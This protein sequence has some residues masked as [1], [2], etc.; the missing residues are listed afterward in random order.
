MT[1]RAEGAVGTVA[2]AGGAVWRPGRD[3]GLETAVVHRPRYDDWS[4]PKGKLDPGEHPLTAAVREVL[5]ETGL[6]AVAGRRSVT[7]RYRVPDGD[8]RVDYWL[9]RVTGG[10]F[11]PNGEVD[12]LRWLSPADAAALVTHDADREVLADLVRTDV[13]P[14]P[15]LVLVRHGKAGSSDAWE[16]PDELRPLTRN[17]EEQARQLAQVLPLLGPTTVATAAPLRCRQTVEPL[18][19]R[20]GLEV[21]DLPEFGEPEFG[22]DPHRALE[23]ALRLLEGPGVTVVCSQG[24]TIPSVLGGL[25]V[26]GHGVP[27]L[28]APAAKGSVWVLGGRPGELSADYYRDLA[29]D[30]DAPS[31]EA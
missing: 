5:E 21:A 11:A 23:T 7:S 29:P 18:A 10:E 31:P 1:S 9:M 8:K 3:G 25:G 17:G 26:H 15:A 16:G 22:G 12:E 28:P 27:G 14:E 19:A 6:Q 2:A 4:L 20:L 13:P 30:R 24:G